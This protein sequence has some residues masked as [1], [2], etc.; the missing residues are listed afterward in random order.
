MGDGVRQFTSLLRKN[1]LL[2][3]RRPCATAFE[4]AL[5]LVLFLLLVYVRTVY[6]TVWY[7]PFYYRNHVLTPFGAASVN[8]LDSKALRDNGAPWAPWF[9]K[10]SSKLPDEDSGLL[11]FSQLAIGEGL[12][13]REF[14]NTVA[15]GLEAVLSFRLAS[16]LT[17]ADEFG[18]VGG[19]KRNVGAP[20]ATG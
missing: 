9:D 11:S 7:G 2:K 16:G 1:V 18:S 13:S 6:E 10:Q 8:E 20:Y 3:C 17:L 15:D 14:K 4:I 19:R 12:C 5:P